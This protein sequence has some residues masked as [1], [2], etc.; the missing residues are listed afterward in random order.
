ME[1]HLGFSQFSMTTNGTITNIWM[2]VFIWLR[3]GTMIAEPFGKRVFG[4]EGRIL[5]AFFHMWNLDLNSI[6]EAIGE[7]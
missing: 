7:E 2:V 5:H 6:R 1:T 3:V 4:S